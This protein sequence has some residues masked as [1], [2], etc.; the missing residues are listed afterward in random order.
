[1]KPNTILPLKFN[2]SRTRISF[3]QEDN[4]SAYLFLGYCNDKI[5]ELSRRLSKKGQLRY[6]LRFKTLKKPP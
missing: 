5:P 6:F 4:H 2:S 1:M 3:Q